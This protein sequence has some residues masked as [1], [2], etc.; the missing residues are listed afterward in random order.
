[1]K[2]KFTP[3]FT[4]YTFNNGIT[5]K[6]R[7]V[8]APMTHWSSDAQGHATFDELAYIKARSAGFGIF[9]TASIAVNPAGISFVGQ[10]VAFS[11]N[12][13]DSLSSVAKTIKSQG[14]LAIAQLQHGG[15]VA[16]TPNPCSPSN[17]NHETLITA[18][19]PITVTATQMTQDDIHQTISD[20]VKSAEL[21]MKAG[22]DGVEIHGANGY[23]L[24]QFFSAKTNRRTDC[25]GG[26][27]ENR[28][29]FGMEITQQ[30]ISL[31]D[32]HHKNDF[33]IGYRI[34]PEEAGE[35]GLTMS[36]TLALVDNLA[37][38]GVQY[39]HISLQDFY[40][41]ARRGA[42][43]DKSRLE[44]IK[45]CL[46]DK[47]V[48]LIGVGKINSAQKAL[49]AINTHTADFVAIGLSALINPNFVTLIEQGKE[50]KIRPMFNLFKSGKHHQM[51]EPMWD[52]VMTFVPKPIVKITGFI[53][54]L[55][56]Y[57]SK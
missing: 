6:N 7:F 5:V 16:I 19:G 44:L 30:L 27:L 37:D 35:N 9:I 10:P 31:K 50:K 40:S 56:G 11:E 4:P 51:P 13:L 38:L 49:N 43:T 15:A 20:F 45:K 53:G 12:D 47:N 14:A 33:I 21:C 2:A 23:L 39:I 42:D 32:K 22:F 1:M 57:K 29:R 54:R 46:D 24:Q 18:S 3:L 17:F 26:N 34:T 36:D 25:Y 52:M 48:A 8:V 55:L 41:K 28:I